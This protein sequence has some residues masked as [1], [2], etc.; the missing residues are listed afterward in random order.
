VLISFLFL[1]RYLKEMKMLVETTS[2]ID[3][4][5]VAGTVPLAG[6]VDV[7][8]SLDTPEGVDHG[9]HLQLQSSTLAASQAGP[10][11]D[12]VNDEL[13]VV[14]SVEKAEIDEEE[15]RFWLEIEA[16]GE[17]AK[18]QRNIQEAES[19]IDSLKSQIKEE[20]EFATGEQI[21]L[22]R[23]A[24]K[25]ADIIEGKPLPTDPNKP[26]D[27]TEKSPAVGSK[28]SDP[29][30]EAVEAEDNAWREVTTST[31]L[32]GMSGIGQKKLDAL[33]A[34]APTAG[35]LE[36]LRGEASLAHKHFK[37]VLP[38]GFGEKIVDVIEEAL[39]ELRKRPT[40]SAAEQAAENKPDVLDK[41]VD[42][43]MASILARCRAAHKKMGHQEDF[44]V[45]GIEPD[46]PD[47]SEDSYANGW[48]AFQS[49]DS[50][51]DCP[52]IP[53]GTDE[54]AEWDEDWI[55]GWAGAEFAANWT[56]VNSL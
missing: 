40:K 16:I 21:R 48:D 4:Y 31:L 2:T 56:A 11:V 10:S 26:V 15:R 33:I 3:D 8:D 12:A 41:P 53:A 39:L 28:L 34:I 52:V 37:E 30:D 32:E 6:A 35:H 9:K 22:Q 55:M 49:G 36:D 19:T 5:S 42:D 47:D 7:D 14:A 44:E 54:S 23:L 38:K 20:K 24:A 25:L 46:N 51:S 43:A 1:V 27:S 13:A 45:S 17:I 18:C 29:A 50:L